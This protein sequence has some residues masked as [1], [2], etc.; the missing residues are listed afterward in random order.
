MSRWSRVEPGEA[1]AALAVAVFHLPLFFGRAIWARDVAYWV[2]P[3]RHVYRQSLLEGALPVW[4]HT[5]GIGLPVLANPLHGVF[6]PP[7]LLALLEPL[8][9]T[10]SLF[11][12]LHVLLGA[13][14]VARLARRMACSPPAS[15]VAGIAWALAGTTL[16]E[17][18]A[19]MRLPG[20]SWIPWIT[21]GA[22]AASERGT[23]RATLRM[24][25]PLA[26]CLLAGEPFIAMF[27]VLVAVAT[28]PASP[29]FDALRADRAKA[30]RAAGLLALSVVTG[31]LVSAVAVLPALAAASGT[32]RGG[33]VDEAVA[34]GWSVPVARFVDLFVVGGFGLASAITQ[35]PYAQALTGPHPLLFSHYLGATVA[36]LALVALRRDRRALTLALV[37]LVAALLAMGRFTPLYAIART[38]LPP[39]KLMRAPEK[40]VAIVSTATP[41]LAALGF[42]RA[43]ASPR[44]QRWMLPIVAALAAVALWAYPPP[45]AA[46]LRAGALQSLAGFALLAVALLAAKRAPRA[47][48]W[49][50]VACV[51][52]DLGHAGSMLLSWRPLAET[53]WRPPVTDALLS[54]FAPGASPAPVRLHRAASLSTQT[55]GFASVAPQLRPF[56]TLP[57]NHATLFGVAAIPPY[58]VAAAPALDDLLGTRRVAVTR[59]LSVDATLQRAHPND[60][61]PAGLRF[62]STAVEGVE[63]LAIEGSLPRVYPVARAT[64]DRRGAVLD[65]D[66]VAGERAVLADGALT[67]DAPPGRPG[68]CALRRMRNGEI[69]A[70]C[71]LDRDAL[72]V[73]VEQHAPGWTA[74]VDG[75]AAP[76][77]T[78]NL[79]AMGRPLARGQFHRIALRSPPGLRAGA[80]ASLVGVALAI[81]L[82][83]VRRRQGA[84][85]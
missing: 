33:A 21:L 18:T 85:S 35:H 54:T 4:N 66:V 10:S 17:W 8:A 69:D 23:L 65:A 56:A 80:L 84:A 64:P 49:V 50:A 45:V 1:A 30:L 44:A 73:F 32:Q 71:A 20:L 43:L 67:L 41:L 11:F 28:V 14:G 19:G 40:F 77:A 6:Y 55:E 58:D 47:A 70:E 68:S 37:A 83:T 34:M 38:L 63:L 53:R 7:T 57:P 29:A 3:S 16:S 22:W 59:L 82:A 15:A 25:L 72:V 62:V 24:S 76:I 79:V 52:L 60:A 36:A 13:I 74:R 39:L 81:T 61:R 2:V 12:F 27:G 75:A 31:A 26:M 5:Q 78:T 46:V 9:W 48:P 51:F 42:D